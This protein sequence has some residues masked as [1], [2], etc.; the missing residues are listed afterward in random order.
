MIGSSLSE[1]YLVEYPNTIATRVGTDLTRMC[2]A[3]VEVQNL[4]AMG[5]FGA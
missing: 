5:Y 2:G 3:P 4:G 1:G